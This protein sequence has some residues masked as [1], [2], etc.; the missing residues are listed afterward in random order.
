M[1]A[2]RMCVPLAIGTWVKDTGASDL[3]AYGRALDLM[4]LGGLQKTTALRLIEGLE[5]EQRGADIAVRFLTVVPFFK[6]RSRAARA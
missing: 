1:R 2:Q 4:G 5:I 3:A 6:V